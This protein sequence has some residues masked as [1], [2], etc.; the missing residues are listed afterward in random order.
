MS[1]ESKI[2]TKSVL[3]YSLLGT[4][5]VPSSPKSGNEAIAL[6]STSGYNK[7]PP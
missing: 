1:T 4:H 7:N 5:Y 6:A 3:P 2:W